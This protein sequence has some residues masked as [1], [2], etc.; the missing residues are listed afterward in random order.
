[1]S[2]LSYAER[3]A[4]WEW[5]RE[6]IDHEA[7]YRADE[8]HPP[9]QGRNVATMYTWQVYSRRATLNPEF[10]HRLG[11]LF[12]DHFIPVYQQQPFQLCAIDPSG[13][14]IA[15]AIMAVAADLGIPVNCFA[16]RRQ[17]KRFGVGNWFDG[18]IV[19]LPVLIVD[20]A[21]ASAEYM[22]VAAARIALKLRL[23]L[24]R[25]Y[26]T[27]SNKVGRLSKAAQHTENYLDNEL[28]SFFTVNNFCQS[29][30]DVK[31]KYGELREWSGI[32]K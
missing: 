23:P 17:Q 27:L 25:N 1:M 8:T 24:H 13:I 14:P 10:A 16:A 11:L 6:F 18:R 30:K 5:C 31:A 19:K 22:R 29:V 21:A 32:V 4:H 15:M 26:F 7:W 20:D 9:I 28:V 3:Q 12:W 2:L